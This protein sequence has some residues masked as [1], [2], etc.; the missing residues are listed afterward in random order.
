MKSLL[1]F[2][3]IENLFK[4][5]IIL[6]PIAIIV[7]PA[8]TDITISLLALFILVNSFIIKDYYYFNN[9]YFKLIFL[10]YIWLLISSILSSNIN[11]SL[12]SSLFYIR[13]LLFASC[14][15]YYFDK[16]KFVQDYFFIILIICV[17]FV[18]LDGF[19]QY[20]T[21]ENILG[22][23][24]EHNGRIS[25]LFKDELILGSY[26]SR[27]IP[28]C[29]FFISYKFGT[30]KIIFNLSIISIIIFDILIFLSGERSAFFYLLITTTGIIFLTVKFKKIRIFTIIISLIIIF[31]ISIFDQN[32]KTRMIDNTIKQ[33]TTSANFIDTGRPIYIFSEEHTDHFITALRMFKDSPIHGQGPK[34]FRKL[35]GNEKYKTVWGCSTHPHNTYLQLLS[36]TG[37]IG[38]FPVFI[39]FLFILYKFVIQFLNIYF[40]NNS[41]KLISD[42][43]IYI[44]LALLISLWPIIPTGN[45][46]GNWINSIYYI[47]IALLMRKNYE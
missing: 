44:Y 34:M 39:M 7:G 33:F 40:F 24:S 43:K 12:E 31:L 23:R 27:L 41:Q 15:A 21:E 45:F 6:F 8:P 22:F 3:I 35:C 38:F 28:L 13:F 30:S 32:S 26:I 36:E 42:E 18:S 29:L 2:N 25:G 1:T 4:Y 14:L 20:I 11:H 46:F 19:I 37:V 17:I 5:L 47:P 9:I 16:Y 10:F